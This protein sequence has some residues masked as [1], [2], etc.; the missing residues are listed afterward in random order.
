MS[1]LKWADQWLSNGVLYTGRV[2]LF[3]DLGK[4]AVR[5]KG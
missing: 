4:S 2:F 5:L 3:A 1:V